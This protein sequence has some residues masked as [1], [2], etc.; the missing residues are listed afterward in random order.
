MTVIAWDGKSLA[1]DRLGDAGGFGTVRTKLRK[2]IGGSN[3]GH[4]A[5]CTGQSDFVEAMHVWYAKGAAPENFPSYQ[6]RDDHSIMVVLQ[7]VQVVAYCQTPY[8]VAVESPF[9]A[10]GSGREF[11]L[12]AMHLGKTAEDAVLVANELCLFCGGGVDVAHGQWPV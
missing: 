8:P 6:S 2:V 4:W 5:A 9:M 7:Y 1:A 11:A 3:D 12:T 10:W